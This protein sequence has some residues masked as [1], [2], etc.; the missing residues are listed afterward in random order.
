MSTGVD[1]S[2]TITIRDIMENAGEPGYVP[3]RPEAKMTGWLAPYQYV[4]RAV[5]ALHALMRN[6]IEEPVE[7]LYTFDQLAR[8]PNKSMHEALSEADELMGGN[9][10]YVQWAKQTV[11]NEGLS[12]V[13]ARVRMQELI[14]QNREPITRDI[15]KL[16]GDRTIY[17]QP[18][19]GLLGGVARGLQTMLRE[20]PVLRYIVPFTNIVANVLDNSINYS[21]VGFIRSLNE[22]V[23]RSY[24]RDVLNKAPDA[25]IGEHEV[26]LLR[27]DLLA[28]A[29][30]GTAGIVGV[31]A[32]SKIPGPNGQPLMSI[33]GNGPTDPK[34]LH[35]MMDE[36]WMPNSVSFNL[37]GMP[38]P[39]YIP[40]EALPISVGLSLIGNVED[41]NRYMQGKDA[42][43][44]ASYIVTQTGSSMV[45]RSFLRGIKDVLDSFAGQADEQKGAASLMRLMAN[46]TAS[47]IPYAGSAMATQ[48]YR[49]LADARVYQQGT[50]W[51]VAADVLRQVPFM[52]WIDGSKP[53]LNVL[54]EPVTSYPFKRMTGQ[55]ASQD[56]I[57]RFLGDNGIFLSDPR[58]PKVLGQK[59]NPEQMYLFTERHGRYLKELMENNLPAL[60]SL[61]DPDIR[62]K[63]MDQF[64][65]MASKRAKADVIQELPPQEP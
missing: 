3:G 46:T 24:F 60:Q 52:N 44:R 12:G 19:E 47:Q 31:W 37:P 13:A 5:T 8:D 63:M 28:K 54:G 6:G 30:M 40:F 7:W 2:R 38:K 36:G 27:Q 16:F 39:Y 10:S 14:D 29:T 35:Q 26:N 64:G 32:L 25:Q 57:W 65:R 21:P 1:P 49:E 53:R 22:D 62:Q 23:A 42:L 45:D 48:L 33:H 50:G 41:S 59:M 58:A 43:A 51:P 11:A 34:K 17:T 4:F 20:V 55:L 61:E 56:P 15:G 18:P 9:A